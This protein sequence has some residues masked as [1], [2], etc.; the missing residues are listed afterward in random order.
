[1]AEREAMER[2]RKKARPKSVDEALQNAIDYDM[3]AA[4]FG[5]G[6]Y[7]D[8]GRK[9]SGIGDAWDSLVGVPARTA[10][11]E[12]QDGNFKS[13]LVKAIKSIGK[14]PEKAPTGFDIASKVT[15]DPLKGAALATL[16][17]VGAQV[18]VGMPVGVTGKVKA[19]PK[20]LQEVDTAEKA[21]AL[22]GAKRA[23]YLK[24]LDEVFGSRD[25]RAA[26]M[27]FGEQTWYHGTGSDFDRFKAEK[28]GS[29]TGEGS[30]KDRFWFSDNPA[31]AS[32]FGD[33]AAK[34]REMRKAHLQE[35]DLLRS[36]GSDADYDALIKVNR[37]RIKDTG[38]LV[39]PVK[40]RDAGIKE[41]DMGG[42]VWMKNA[43]E[44]PGGAIK[45]KNFYENAGPE[46]GTPMGT[47]LGTLNASKIRSVN[48]AFDPRFKDSPLLL[49][50]KAGV[51]PADM[52]LNAS[53]L[54]KD[55][56]ESSEP[57]MDLEKLSDAELEA[58]ASGKRPQAAQPSL[59]DLSDDE[60]M[61]LAGEKPLENP[62]LLER[63][64]KGVLEGVSKAGQAVDSV[65]G[66]PSRAAF[67]A[68]MD[69]KSP[70][71]AFAQQFAGDP[72][73][74]PTGLELAVK[75]GFNTE[76]PVYRT[77]ADQQAHDERYNPNVAQIE[78]MKGGY[79]DQKRFSN[80]ELT[81]FAADVGLDYTNAI[82]VGAMLRGA[83]KLTKGAGQVG[84]KGM[85][86][87]GEVAAPPA[88]KV[89]QAT[90]DVLSK[91]KIGA[92]A[93]DS[94]KTAKRVL[95]SF[96]N[97]KQVENIGEIEALVRRKGLDP[98]MLPESIK[99]GPG[100]SISRIARG[101]RENPLTG[102]QEMERF[103][104]W[105]NQLDAAIDDEVVRLGGGP[106]LEPVEAGNLIKTSYE[107]AVDRLFNERAVMTYDNVV[108]AMPGIELTG[109]ARSRVESKINGI[110]R[111]AKGRMQRGFTAT[112]R[113]QGEQVLRAIEAVKAGNGSLKQT[114]ET[115][116]DIGRVAYRQ[117]KTAMSDVP[118][119]IEKFRDL[120]DTLSE[121]FVD[122][123]RYVGGND[124]A[125]ALEDTNKEISSFLKNKEPIARLLD[126][127]R[128]AP[129]K[130]FRNLVVAG[131]TKQLQALKEMVT[132]EEFN[133]LRA[134]YVGSLITRNS[135]DAV[136]AGALR[137]RLQKNT[138]TL[139]VLFEPD[140]IKDLIEL[141]KLKEKGGP[142]VLSTSGTGASNILRDVYEAVKS[143]VA[144]KSTLKVLKDSADARA[145]G[146]IPPAPLMPGAAVAEGAQA[147]I[148]GSPT[149]KAIKLG[150]KRPSR[151]RI[152]ETTKLLQII[153]T[154][155]ESKKREEKKA[156]ERRLQEIIEKRLSK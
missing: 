100:S 139:S 15:D 56:K 17:D 19:L 59:E 55:D 147:I 79:Q 102:E 66:A 150:F 62:S 70:L 136:N 64:G 144:N 95:E 29:H 3:G 5:Q 4:L 12:M 128:I 125:K 8:T 110:E 14:D 85:G 1:M 116:L 113:A 87:I 74:A 39:M 145:K 45:L 137:S 67:G 26:D 25:K 126:N 78:K 76:R 38:G 81:G 156:A 40:I 27:G 44:I 134:S 123:T 155:D 47:S 42:K 68:W 153:S 41:K 36:G 72:S 33:S 7:R 18:P 99:Y 135:D 89:L 106:A 140:E 151:G 98:E 119:D 60:L 43:S 94:T 124:M 11:A 58:I 109:A 52:R 103:I 118:P 32:E 120:Y 57:I 92:I 75:G 96:F 121:A 82:P 122:S 49:A 6:E 133:R 143:G 141:V 90:E 97:P 30:T 28:L 13:A 83:G 138:A 86:K 111:W 115:M 61:Q 131:D 73:K 50:G 114:Y 21:V 35:D 107:K 53:Q 31:V 20:I 48:A 132:P 93:V 24:A 142:A 127:N 34:I 117:S 9:S 23:E 84:L 88:A 101:V 71:S 104:Q 65:T 112:D 129:E 148:P 108:K 154:M 80:A 146:I 63:M 105:N 2:R 10:I 46:S 77:A 69:G 37:D 16:I 149:E 130:L 91:S 152:E 22:K 51:N 54:T